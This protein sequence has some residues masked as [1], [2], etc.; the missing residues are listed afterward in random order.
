MAGVKL[1]PNM[2]AMWEPKST[3]L[4]TSGK[5]GVVNVKAYAYDSGTR[6]IAALYGEG[7]PESVDALKVAL[8][9]PKFDKLKLG[10]STYS[11]GWAAGQWKV[12]P[13]TYLKELR[14]SVIVAYPPTMVDYNPEKHKECFIIQDG[15]MVTHWFAELFF[16]RLS[17]IVNIAVQRSWSPVLM[18]QGERYRLFTPIIGEGC[19][20]WKFE[21]DPA[22]WTTLITKLISTKEITLTKEG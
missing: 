5:D 9:D 12:L 15:E 10:F 13:P 21:T 11:I 17:S 8:R 16:K 4:T 18:Q 3:R 6:S 19:R 20:V 2:V 1:E 14:R 22:K 7:S